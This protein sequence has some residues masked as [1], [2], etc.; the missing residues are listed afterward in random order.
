MKEIN[1]I[2]IVKDL[3]FDKEREEYKVPDKN[4]DILVSAIG[5]LVKSKKVGFDFE[6]SVT[7][8]RPKIVDMDIVVICSQFNDDDSHYKIRDIFNKTFIS[9][10]EVLSIKDIKDWIKEFYA[11]HYL[12]PTDIEYHAACLTILH[13]VS[14]IYCSK[15]VDIVD[16]SDYYK[17]FDFSLKSYYKDHINRDDKLIVDE[18]LLALMYGISQTL[19]NQEMRD[20]AIL[21]GGNCENE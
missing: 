9:G 6:N 20:K 7:I 16:V 3:L 11:H 5:D 17:C 8:R 15:L 12:I 21:R 10:I 2:E 18:D 13:F 4:I 1:I 14:T 19:H